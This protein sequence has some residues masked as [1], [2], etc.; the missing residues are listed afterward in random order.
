MP[1]KQRAPKTRLRSPLS[2][3]L[4]YKLMTGEF[5]DARLHGWVD[6]ATTLTRDLPAILEAAWADYGDELSDEAAA[7]GFEPWG[8]RRKRP[9]RA[10]QP[11]SAAFIAAHR[12]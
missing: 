11:W 10:A 6:L 4:H 5:A 7:A 8:R 9:G 3:A 12:Y 1:R 2:D